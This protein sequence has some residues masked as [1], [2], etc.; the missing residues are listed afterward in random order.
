MIQL[1][2]KIENSL[3]NL[4]S[5]L[6][7]KAS[8]YLESNNDTIG[9]S[10]LNKSTGVFLARIDVLKMIDEAFDSL[11]DEQ[12]RTLRKC[13]ISL[14]NKNAPSTAATVTSGTNQNNQL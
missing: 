8:A 6:E 11:S 10:Y 7:E 13:G 2:D 5:N 4:E 14:K 1:R 9:N 12:V 3:E